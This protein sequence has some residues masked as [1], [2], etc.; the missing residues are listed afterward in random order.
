MLERAGILLGHKGV[1]VSP[2]PW[3]PCRPG[4]RGQRQPW[5]GCWGPECSYGLGPDPPWALGFSLVSQGP[6]GELSDGQPL[7]RP[8]LGVLRSHQVVWP[9]RWGAPSPGGGDS[10]PA[11][12]PHSVSRCPPSPSCALGA[13]PGAGGTRCA[14]PGSVPAL[15]GF[16]SHGS[17]RF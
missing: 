13:A 1:R 11:L 7:Q 3:V 17:D 4:C 9:P 10:G 16:G 15:P 14:K 6:A 5:T 12:L 2:L 8:H